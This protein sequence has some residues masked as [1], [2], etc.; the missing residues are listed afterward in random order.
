MA[1]SYRYSTLPQTIREMQAFE[2]GPIVNG[3]GAVELAADYQFAFMTTFA[4]VLDR[5]VYLMHEYHIAPYPNLQ[6]PT[7][8]ASLSLT[9]HLF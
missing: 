9:M 7:L 5:D 1:W 2:W 3:L 6:L 8:T 4:T